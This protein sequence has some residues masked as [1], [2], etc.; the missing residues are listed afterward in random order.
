MKRKKN[1][2]YG[3][4]FKM[5]ALIYSILLEQAQKSNQETGGI[6]ARDEIITHQI[7]GSR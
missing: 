4:Y 1:I 2:E 3:I 6:E 7:Q 5:E